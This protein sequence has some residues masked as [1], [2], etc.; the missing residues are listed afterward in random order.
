MQV[1]VEENVAQYVSTAMLL[2]NYKIAIRWFKLFFKLTLC[3]FILF[4]DL[5][6]G[7]FHVTV[8]I[9]ERSLV[10]WYGGSALCKVIRFL[11]VRYI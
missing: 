9:A 6:V 3:P 2:N 1:V 4:S 11:Q 7:L 8:D 5:T 10:T